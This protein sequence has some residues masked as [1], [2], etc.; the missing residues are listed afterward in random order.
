MTPTLGIPGYYVWG[1]IFV[2]SIVISSVGYITVPDRE[3]S[4]EG[5]DEDSDPV[6]AGW[7]MSCH[8]VVSNVSNVSGGSGGSGGQHQNIQ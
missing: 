8:W 1:T 4:W 2:T 5:E 3:K 7:Q 6:R